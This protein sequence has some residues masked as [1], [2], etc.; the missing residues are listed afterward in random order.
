MNTEQKYEDTHCQKPPL[1][2]V[3]RPIRDRERCQE[4]IEAIARYNE[5]GKPVPAEWLEELSEKLL[6]SVDRAVNGAKMATDPEVLTKA[7]EHVRAWLDGML[8]CIHRRSWETVCIPADSAFYFL[9][10]ID[11]ALREGRTNR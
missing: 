3:P 8:A 2:L 5:A 6:T 11:K 7:L 9:D 1:G 10:E 4:I